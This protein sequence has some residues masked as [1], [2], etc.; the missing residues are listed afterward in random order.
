MSN[1]IFVNLKKVI[2]LQWRDSMH[3]NCS[4]VKDEN[5]LWSSKV[6][7]LLKTK[8]KNK[9]RLRGKINF[10]KRTRQRYSHWLINSRNS[11]KTGESVL[12]CT[13]VVLHWGLILCQNKNKIFAFQSEAMLKF[14]LVIPKILPALQLNECEMTTL[15]AGMVARKTT[16]KT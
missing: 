12:P 5:F 9:T 13:A 4:W 11:I 8:E 16:V 7:T 2:L 3:K 14:P 15:K 1:D 10:H 6:T